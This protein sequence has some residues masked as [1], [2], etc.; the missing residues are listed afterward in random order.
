MNPRSIDSS[1]SAAWWNC[2]LLICAFSIGAVLLRAQSAGSV[3][4]TATDSSGGSFPAA[5]VSLTN[6]GTSE[7]RSSVTDSNGNYQFVSVVPGTY[8]IEIQKEGFKRFF[9][10]VAVR[11]DTTLR[12]DAVMQVG[13]VTQLVEVSSQVPL[14]QTDSASLGQVVEGRQVEEMPLNGRNVMNLVSLAPGVIIQGGAGGSPLNNQAASG[15]FTNPQGWGNYQIG[16]GQSGMSAQVLDG[17]SINSTFRNSPVL[18]PTQDLI[19]EFRVASNNVS[20]EFGGFSG[21]VISLSS[22]SGTNGFHGSAYEYFR[23]TVLNANNFFNNS[24]GQPVA[25]F[26]Q[27]QFGG[28]VGGPVRKDKTFFFFS[29]ERYTHR[30]GLPLLFFVPTPAQLAG[31]FASGKTI[32]D[33]LTTCGLS[34]TPACAPGAPTRTPFSNN[35]IPATRIDSFADA[36]INKIKI[37]A[38]PNTN[39]PGGNFTNNSATGGWSNQFSIRGDHNLSDRQRLFVR[40]THW[41][42]WTM[43]QN[44]FNNTP[45]QGQ[46]SK[47]PTAAHD[48]VVGDTVTLSP[49]TQADFR[50]AFHRLYFQLTPSSYGMDISPIGPA[51]A[52]LQPQLSSTQLPGID[53]PGYEWRTFL[54]IGQVISPS[55]NNEFLFYGNLTKTTGR[56]TIKVGADVRNDFFAYIQANEA[57]GAFSYTNAYT[58]LN[59]QAGDPNG[60]PIASFLLGYPSQGLLQVYSNTNQR[61]WWQGFYVN[62]TFQVTR[63]LTLNL[64]L[65]WE[66]PAVW[67]IGHDSGTVLQLGASDPLA[68][69]TGLPLKGQLALVNSDLYPDRHVQN[70]NFHLFSPRVGIAYRL[71]DKTVIR[72]GFARSY[73]PTSISLGVSGSSSP[74]NVALTTMNSGLG[75]L[76]GDT[77]S[78][79]F[80]NGILT[81]LGRNPAYVNNVEGNSISGS[82]P[83]SPFPHSDQWNFSIGRQLTAN[84]SL[85]VS[86]SGNKGTHLPSFN[87]GVNMNALPDQYLSLGSA[88]LNQVPNPFYGKLPALANSRLTGP[89][90]QAGMLLKP[91]PQ[92]INVTNS[93]SYQGNSIYNSLQAKFQQRFKSGGTILVSYA[94][95]KLIGN[96]DGL[97]GFLESQVGA[98]QDPNN[99]QAERS[100]TSFDVPQRLSASYVIDLPVGK[101][102]RFLNDV[103]GVTDK[104]LSGWGFN[105]ITTFQSGYPLQITAQG[106]N[107][108]SFFGAG[109]IR[110]NFVYGCDQKRS[111]SAQARLNEWFNINCFTQP[112]PFSFGNM[113]RTDG[114]LR[115]SGINNFDLAMFKRTTITEQVRLEF[116]AECFN[117]ANRVQFGFPNTSLNPSQLGTSANLFGKVTSTLNQPRLFQLALRLS[118]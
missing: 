59:G 85:D 88:L 50:L 53:L 9:A 15:N 73:L 64:G 43:S 30:Q 82:L 110:P 93:A 7:R 46:G 79:P 76:P 70:R 40:Y 8:R 13:D 20:A 22:K 66:L 107:L 100:L 56:H 87:G 19:Q 71:N 111:G 104:L 99:L 1:T 106:N 112:G 2:K 25:P 113:G 90:I 49:T 95:S 118:F 78:N 14:L 103:N 80:P 35:I 42:T 75:F 37:L 48:A 5:S 11:V 38:P 52:K 61:D 12:I 39:V 51:Y 6:L 33:P 97:F 27:H 67:R 65:R 16:G 58:G 28:T 81:P 91:Y 109:T 24:T 114:A 21:G 115:G 69:T 83:D 17:V 18:V 105:G 10:E 98:V 41:D 44:L 55:T 57:A 86:Y 54:G 26:K 31:N 96:A 89:T 102:K 94:W 116:R 101:G 68:K 117:V 63:K 29:Y 60:N 4:G 77:T 34:G 47:Q 62:D 3:V 36:M 92:Y 45:N 23:N 72:T 84:S 108:S 74:V 32:Y